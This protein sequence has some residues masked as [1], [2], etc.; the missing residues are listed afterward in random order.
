MK[1]LDSVALLLSNSQIPLVALKNSGITRGLYPY[2]GAC[3]MG[4]IDVLVRRSDFRK[5]HELLIANG[6][7]MKFRSPLETENLEVAERHGGAEYS[8]DL[9]SGEHLWFELQW[10]PVAGR[11]IRPDQEPDAS[12]YL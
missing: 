4:D 8:V 6:Y 9:P 7:K 2:Y 3:P 12:G 5:A 1:E 11:W 10:R